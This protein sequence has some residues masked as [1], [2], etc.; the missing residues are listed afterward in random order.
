MHG[1]LLI[2]MGAMN[3]GMWNDISI[4][5][6]VLGRHVEDVCNENGKTLLQFRSEH[7]LWISSRCFPHEIVHKVVGKEARKQACN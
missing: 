7:S 1:I 3:I 5:E 6:E 2:V 4:W